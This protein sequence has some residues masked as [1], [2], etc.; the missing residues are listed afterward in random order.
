MVC[1]DT[2][3]DLPK[4][5]FAKNT[6]Q[7]HIFPGNA[8]LWACRDGESRV[9]EFR[10]WQVPLKLECP[11]ALM[12]GSAPLLPRYYQTSSNT[13]AKIQ[14]LGW[15]KC[16]ECS[17]VSDPGN[18]HHPVPSESWPHILRIPI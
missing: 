3:I 15:E 6:I 2:F 12:P 18:S 9:P 5:A 11:Q 17:I 14:G 1:V 10:T 13:S 4:K 8:I 16:L 7:N